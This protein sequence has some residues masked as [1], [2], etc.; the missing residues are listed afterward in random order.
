LDVIRGRDYEEAL[1]ILEFLPQR[2]SEHVRTPAQPRKPYPSQ[3]LA[4]IQNLVLSCASN[5]KNTLGMKKSTLYI[6]ECFADQGAYMKRFQPRAQGRAYQILKPLCSIS[7]K[8]RSHESSKRTR[9]PI[10]LSKH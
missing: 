7:L 3:P 10:K 2:C 4:Q 9:G 1:M 6:S 8:M 5:A